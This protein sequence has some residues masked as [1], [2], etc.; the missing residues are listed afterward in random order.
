MKVMEFGADYHDLAEFYWETG[1]KKKSLQI[2]QKGL[3]KARGRMNELLVFVAEWAQE[4]G[5]RAT[6]IELQF[7]QTT[8]GLTFDKYK[9]FK[10][11]CTKEEWEA[12]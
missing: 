6:W 5:D 9:K 3:K 10:T 12:I 7:D 4:S 8:D 11:D 2:A 1:E